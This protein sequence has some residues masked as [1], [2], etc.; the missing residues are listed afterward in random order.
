MVD[1]YIGIELTRH[2]NLRCAHCFRADLD[3]VNEIPYE[4]VEKILDQAGHYHKPH[5]AM[6]GGET[7]LH[8]HFVDILELIIRKGY[9]FHFVT[10][11]FNYKS[12]FQ[13]VFHL[14]GNPQWIGVSVSLDGATAE[15][16]DAIRGPG[17]FA[18]ALACVAT[19]K[20]HNLECVAQMV[21]HRG[22]RH[23][24]E[25]MALLCSKMNTNRLHIAHM[26]PTPHAVEHGLMHSPEEERQVEQEICDLQGRFRMPIVLS[27][28]F[29]DQT[30]IAHCRFLK[31]GALNVD[32][33]GRLTTCCQLSNLEGSDGEADV[34][35]DLTKTPLETAHGALL[36]TYN[37]VYASRLQKMAD[38]TMH[39]LDNFHCWSCMKHFKKVEWMRDFPQN[40]WVQQDPYFSAGGKK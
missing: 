3:K 2:C 30:P 25:A 40:E 21:V 9:T 23:E 27:A 16:H 20:S 28:G 24:L 1:F 12:V 33:R 31:L 19:V 29:Y 15:T 35:A 39:D 18:R 4:T 34:V 32:H 5:I 36:Q 38:G 6:T 22:N 11:G 14:F 7:T 37:K 26:Q 13:K 10:N 17:S 8:S